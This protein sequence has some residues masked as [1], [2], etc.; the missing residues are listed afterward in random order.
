MKKV[1]ALLMSLLLMLSLCACTITAGRE[2]EPAEEISQTAETAEETAD[3]SAD[4]PENEDEPD[5]LTFPLTLG[6]GALTV[7]SVFT[8]DMTNPDCD[9]ES[10][11][12]LASLQVTNT[13]SDCIAEAM[14][15][16]VMADGTTASFTIM[17]LPAGMSM[18]AFDT[19]DTALKSTDCSSLTLESLTIGEIGIPEEVSVSA[20]STSITVTNNSG[21]TL[22]NLTVTYHCMMDGVCFGG[23]SYEQIIADLPA[24]ASITLEADECWLGT[25][26]VL[27]ITME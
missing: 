24:G 26:E 11:E 27:G 9:N 23:L 22:E 13:G 17:N 12:D 19:A 15:T 3:E 18:L 7:E 16:A 6:D 25:A 5:Y 14:V 2:E 1:T 10:V 21:S 20:E 8:S 4:E